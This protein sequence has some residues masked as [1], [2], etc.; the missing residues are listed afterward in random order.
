MLLPIMPTPAEVLAAKFNSEDF[1]ERVS[2]ESE[3]KTRKRAERRKELFEKKIKASSR[4]VAWIDILGFSQQMQMVKTDADWQAA[5]RKMLSVHELFAKVSASDEPE[6]QA[7]I[8]ENYGRTILAL[9][10]G[11]VVTAGLHA[12]AVQ[13]MSPYDLL[14]SL[15]GEI[16]TAQAHCALVG[17]F[18]R[19]GIGTGRFYFDNDILLSPALIRAYKLESERADYPAIVIAKETV[20]TLSSLPGIRHYA[21]GCEPSLAYFRPFKSPRQKKGERF[22]FL[23]YLS[24]IAEP[25][26]HGFNRDADRV[27]Y[28]RTRDPKKRQRIYDLSHWKCALHFMTRHKENLITA[29]RSSSSERVKSKYRWLMRYHNRTIERFGEFHA[30]ALIDLRKFSDHARKRTHSAS[31]KSL[32]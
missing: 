10:D 28:T 25:N 26:N 30:P 21:K 22:Y 3:E 24:Y 27:A 4:V 7:E 16:L 8:N 15:V 13:M 5:Y 32:S 12:K 2:R 20:E 17:I 23:D 9:S 31:L 29:Y 6:V 19:G 18:L 11:L 1:M 14:M